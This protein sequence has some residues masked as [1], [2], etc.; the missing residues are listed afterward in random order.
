MLDVYIYKTFIKCSSKPFKVIWPLISEGTR[1]FS[2]NGILQKSTRQSSKYANQVCKAASYLWGHDYYKW[3]NF[4]KSSL[5]P[6]INLHKTGFQKDVLNKQ[7][8]TSLVGK[9]SSD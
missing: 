1:M 9:R 3:I 2:Q 4:N 6:F 5:K 7:G 8:D